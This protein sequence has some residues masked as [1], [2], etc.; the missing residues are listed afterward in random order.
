MSRRCASLE[1]L[2]IGAKARPTVRRRRGFTLIEL[3]VVTS[4]VL[5]LAIAT[6]PVIIRLNR[7][8]SL[9]DATRI[10]QATLVGA[11]GRAI[12]QQRP[13]GV[14]FIPDDANPEIFRTAILIQEGNVFSAGTVHIVR[15]NAS[16]LTAYPLPPLP[17]NILPAAPTQQYSG[18]SIGS[19]NLVV[20]NNVD[21]SPFLSGGGTI[22][23]E[24]AG[25]Y[26]GFDVVPTSAPNTMLVLRSGAFPAPIFNPLALSK[27]TPPTSSQ[28]FLSNLIDPQNEGVRYAIFRETVP[29]EGIDP[30]QLPSGVVMDLGWVAAQFAA[31]PKAEDRLSRI[32]RSPQ[33]WVEILFSPSGQVLPPQSQNALLGLWLRDDSAQMTSD[34]N[35]RKY[36]RA[37]DQASHAIVTINTVSGFIGSV[38]PVFNDGPPTSATPD[39]VFD[40]DAYYR[41]AQ[42]GETRGL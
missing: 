21:F 41:N 5:L 10:V 26:Y 40:F 16:I 3:L 27:P 36:V 39:G 14:R 33:G 35:G 30:I 22:R 12:A 2:V 11:R 6:T 17:P 37:S 7:G 19:V 29:L 24:N 34:G 23:F 18:S 20:G 42:A 8:R 4:L 38:R 28:T 13:I 25:A 9:G 15:P 31:V 1:S 32:E